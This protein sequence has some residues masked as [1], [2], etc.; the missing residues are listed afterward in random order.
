MGLLKEIFVENQFTT[1][2]AVHKADIRDLLK[3]LLT[4]SMRE[5]SNETRKKK[6]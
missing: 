5:L 1:L 3:L 2:Q 6:K 4:V